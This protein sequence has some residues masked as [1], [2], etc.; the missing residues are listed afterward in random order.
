MFLRYKEFELL[1]Q[2]LQPQQRANPLV[3]WVFID[4]QNVIPLIP[5]NVGW[6]VTS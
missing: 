5:L 4:D 1:V 3:E 6:R 2:V